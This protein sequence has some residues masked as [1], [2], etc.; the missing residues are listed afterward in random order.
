[1]IDTVAVCMWLMI[2]SDSPEEEEKPQLLIYFPGI[3]NWHSKHNTK[4]SVLQNT[5]MG[6]QMEHKRKSAKH[7]IW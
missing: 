2:E 1:M 5:S 6:Y 3:F 7:T 4:Y